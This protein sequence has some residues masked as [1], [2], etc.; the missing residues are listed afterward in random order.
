M[1]GKTRTFEVVVE[2]DEDDLLVASVSELA[3]CH[4][5]AKSIEI[6]RERIF[7]AI[8]TY[9]GEVPARVVLKW[10]FVR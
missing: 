5:Q 1:V 6:L 7:E 9:L 3:G 10:K 2:H 8:C 4:T